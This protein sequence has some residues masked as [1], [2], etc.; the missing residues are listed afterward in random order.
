MGDPVFS[1]MFTSPPLLFLVFLTLELAFLKNT[2]YVSCE[3]FKFGP[4][5]ATQYQDY[6]READVRRALKTVTSCFKDIIKDSQYEL[7]R[8]ENKKVLDIGSGLGL[9]NIELFE[10][11]SRIGI[12]PTVHLHNI[13]TDNSKFGGFIYTQQEN[14]ELEK[15]PL[16]FFNSSRSGLKCA[17]SI[18]E[19]N[20]IP[21][22][23]LEILSEADSINKLPSSSFWFAYSLLSMGTHFSV[24]E[25]WEDL[26][27]I[28]EPGGKVLFHLKRGQSMSEQVKI[29]KNSKF[30]CFCANS[31]SR[32]KSCG[33]L[34]GFRLIDTPSADK[35]CWTN[36]RL[37]NHHKFQIYCIKKL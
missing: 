30:V 23:N 18:A 15:L 36:R 25:Y 19:V 8:H 29:I 26:Y 4:T 34:T 10:E 22:Q 27:R 37:I 9:Y 13:N 20:G 6:F 33:K 2:L 3:P 11:L 17:K 14:G 7:N 5:C 35:A 12:T 16:L 28:L 24:R 32:N 1:G 21:S 31:S